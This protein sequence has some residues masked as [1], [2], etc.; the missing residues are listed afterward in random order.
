MKLRYIIF[1]FLM[2]LFFKLSAQNNKIGVNLGYYEN[3]S[4]NQFKLISLKYYVN[5]L[6]DSCQ[7]L[8]LWVEPSYESV[9][10]N[11]FKA[12]YLSLGLGA[13]LFIGKKVSFIIGGG[14]LIKNLI[15]SHSQFYQL[16]NRVFSTK[17][18]T[19]VGV[20]FSN[21]FISVQGIYMKDITPTSFWEKPNQIKGSTKI[22]N[23]ENQ[24]FLILTIGYLIKN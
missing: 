18:N 12:D 7:E 9:K 6:C 19:G 1:L 14:M 20:N 3:K 24:P 17:I 2:G 21:F 11:S 10:K 23:Y 22:A 8:N 4:S 5:N 15:N 13:D 16:K